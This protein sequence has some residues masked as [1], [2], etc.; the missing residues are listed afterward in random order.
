MLACPPCVAPCLHFHQK[1]PVG[2][3][4]DEKKLKTGK[5][6]VTPHIRFVLSNQAVYTCGRTQ[7]IFL[8]YHQKNTS[9]HQY[10][11]TGVALRH[12]FFIFLQ[13]SSVHMHSPSLQLLL[14]IFSTRSERLMLHKCLVFK[15]LRHTQYHKERMGKHKQQPMGHW[16][17]LKSSSSSS[18]CTSH[19]NW[20]T[21]DSETTECIPRLHLL[22]KWWGTTHK[23]WV[24][25][26][27][28]YFNYK[29]AHHTKATP[30]V[31]F[32]CGE[33]G[34]LSF[35]TRKLLHHT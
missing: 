30:M 13:D 31:P 28:F 23:S 15:K 20:R 24:I 5:Q 18:I 27:N 7:S 6:I 17:G 19:L 22:W 11:T 34:R 9:N 8:S 35:P 29:G 21:C 33:A 12:W 3:A 16:V 25:M 1:R 2:M 10:C 26:S 4:C 14:S 32:F